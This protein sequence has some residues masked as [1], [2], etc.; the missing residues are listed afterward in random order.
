MKRLLT[1]TLTLTN[2]KLTTNKLYEKQNLV[3]SSYPPYQTKQNKKH[4]QRIKLIS[5]IL[6][7]SANKTKNVTNPN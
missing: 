3:L 1:I 5:Y 4:K 7:T 6:C 2:H